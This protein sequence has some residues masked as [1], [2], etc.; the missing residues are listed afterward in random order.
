MLRIIPADTAEEPYRAPDIEL[1]DF[2]IGDLLLNGFDHEAQPGDFRSEQGIRTQVII[3]L[4]TDRRVE[5]S[6]L[7]DGDE[8]R[9]WVGDSFD[10]EDGETPLGSRLWLLRRSALT[11][12]ILPMAEL[13]AR[14]ALQPLLAQNVVVRVAVKASIDKQAQRLDLAVALYGRDGAT[15]F[16]EKFGMLWRQVDVAG[17]LAR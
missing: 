10:L 11:D 12:G 13:Y 15:V 8:N 5:R 14:D 3:C 17:T 4:M 7:R 2:G 9:G 6:E 1:D 16:N